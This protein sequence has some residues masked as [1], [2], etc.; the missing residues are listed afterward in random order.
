MN[1]FAYILICLIC[2]VGGLFTMF[3]IE[4]GLPPKTTIQNIQQIQTV[5]NKN[6]SIQS[7]DQAQITTTVIT[8]NT[9]YHIAINYNGRTNISQSFTSKTN[10]TAKTNTRKE[11]PLIPGIKLPIP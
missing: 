3:G 8:A 10:R 6:T 2:F 4:S 9:N 1:I 7:S 5:D 11:K